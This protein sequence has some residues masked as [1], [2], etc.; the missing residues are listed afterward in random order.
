MNIFEKLKEKFGNI[1]VLTMSNRHD[2]QQ[3]IIHQLEQIGLQDKNDINIIYATPFPYNNI[4]AD[5]F[6]ATNKGKFTKPNEF[7]CARNHYGMVKRS[8][9]LWHNRCL[10]IEDD[11]LFINDESIWDKYINAIPDDFDILQFGGFT[12]D[13]NVTKY[14][15]EDKIPWTKHKDVGLWNCSMYAL[16]RKGMEYYI[17]FMNKI[18]WVA[19]GPLYKAPI[20]DKIINTYMPSIPLVIQADKNVM[21]SDIRTASTDSIDYNN[22]NKYEQF[23]KNYNYI[24]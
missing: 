13:P 2:R 8:Y 7:D 24:Q 18:F 20:N 16:S 12:V 15:G 17:R 1:Y 4:I 22:D 19:D 3:H 6:N 5:A 14:L 9:D 11:I 21:T 23:I 10:I